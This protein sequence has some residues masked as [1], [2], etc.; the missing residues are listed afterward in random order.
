MKALIGTF[1]LIAFISLST[2]NAVSCVPQ[3][4][5]AQQIMEDD[6]GIVKLNPALEVAT[7]AEVA[8]CNSY[9]KSESGTSTS[10]VAISE[11]W[12]TFRQAQ[13]QTTIKP[14][15]LTNPIIRYPL[16]YPSTKA[17]GYS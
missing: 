15:Y 3:I 1:M 5:Q 11:R 16:K 14:H 4:D 17:Y 12:A 7:A 10:T 9:S 6:V 13:G 2:G 8:G